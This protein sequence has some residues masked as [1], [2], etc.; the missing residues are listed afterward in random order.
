MY[1]CTFT[2]RRHHVTHRISYPFHSHCIII[3]PVF[4]NLGSVVSPQ[5]ILLRQVMLYLNSGS[6][7]LR[8][9]IL[10]VLAMAVVRFFS[11]YFMS[12]AFGI[13]SVFTGGY[14]TF[15]RALG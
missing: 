1:I 10:L 12:G 8:D 6:D 4:G 15:Y 5:S 7:Q 3:A 13:T 2:I 11:V 9:A 14:C